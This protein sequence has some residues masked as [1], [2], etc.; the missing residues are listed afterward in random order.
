MSHSDEKD[1]KQITEPEAITEDVFG[2]T[3]DISDMDTD[4]KE[5]EMLGDI[6]IPDTFTPCLDKDNIPVQELILSTRAVVERLGI[7]HRNVV[8]RYTNT[9]Y[10][11]LSVKKDPLNDRYLYTEESVKQLAFIMN[12]VKNSGRSFRQELEYLE[13]YDGRKMMSVASDNVGTLEKMFNQMQEN[14][15]K[16]NNAQIQEMRNELRE[17]MHLNRAL[18]EDK[19]LSQLEERME[20]QEELMRTI[21]EQKD[22]EIRELKMQLEQKKKP[23][24]SFGKK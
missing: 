22:E 8:L 24:W 14:I 21:I 19:T 4:E 23:F 6:E 16:A 1:T 2:E 7:A 9:F 18:L 15:I 13:S 5:I 11:L 17:G 10:D 12:D 3:S 20:K